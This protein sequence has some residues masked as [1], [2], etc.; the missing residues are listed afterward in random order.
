MWTWFVTAA[1]ADP[2]DVLIDAEAW[3][4][5]LDRAAEQLAGPNIAGGQA[6]LNSA[7]NRATCLATRV[8]PAD[9][10]LLARLEAV[11]AYFKQELDQV[12]DWAKLAAVVEPTSSMPAWIDEA[13]PVR[14]FLDRPPPGWSG[15]PEQAVEVPKK[16]GVFL[17]GLWLD[18]PIFPTATPCLIQVLDK[19]GRRIDSWWQHG[20]AAPPGQLVPTDEA[21]PAPKF[22]AGPTVSERAG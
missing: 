18:R 17:N 16:G 1:W 20:A 19:S 5:Q 22:Y 11:S 2:C 9:L 14:S 7:K 8:D 15:W 3:R 21:P 13:H 6:T 10:T 12:E 4:W